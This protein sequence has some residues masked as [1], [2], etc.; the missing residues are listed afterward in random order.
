MNVHAYS[1]LDS[2]FITAIITLDAKNANN[3]RKTIFLDTAKA[4]LSDNLIVHIMYSGPT[5]SRLNEAGMCSA[6]S[7]VVIK[8]LSFLTKA[9]R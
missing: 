4:V 5:T 2:S 6:S 1:S 7:L 9:A 3:A 8:V